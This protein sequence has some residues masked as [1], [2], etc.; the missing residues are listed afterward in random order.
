MTKS[1]VSR[2]DNA[3]EQLRLNMPDREVKALGQLFS[4]Q[5]RQ[6][7]KAKE[8][9]RFYADPNNYIRN[10]GYIAHLTNKSWSNPNIKKD[11][12]EKA[13]QILKELEGSDD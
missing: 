3:L 9:L 10:K 1:L 12:G 5:Q 11:G 4:E 7:E 8:V 2:I 13:K 6:L